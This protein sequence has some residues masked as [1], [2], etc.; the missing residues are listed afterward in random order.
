MQAD[1]SGRVELDV[2]I[3]DGARVVAEMLHPTHTQFVVGLD[4]LRG[5]LLGAQKCLELIEHLGLAPAGE[6]PTKTMG[7]CFTRPPSP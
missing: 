6:S 2:P 7:M 3:S 5:G 4:Q 1:A